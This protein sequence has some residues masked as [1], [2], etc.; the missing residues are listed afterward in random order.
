MQCW[1]P[2]QTI[3]TLSLLNMVHRVFHHRNC[4]QVPVQHNTGPKDLD[5]PGLYVFYKPS[6]MY[7]V[8]P[9]FAFPGVFSCNRFGTMGL[10]ESLMRTHG[11]QG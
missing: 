10:C 2:S 7:N 11:R 4:A 1:L 3:S 8:A 6:G 9:P 5:K